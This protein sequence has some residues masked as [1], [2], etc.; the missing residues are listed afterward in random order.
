MRTPVAK[1]YGSAE[2]TVT[3]FNTDVN[4]R[5]MLRMKNNTRRRLCK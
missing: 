1:R 2:D 4:R 5:R 3:T